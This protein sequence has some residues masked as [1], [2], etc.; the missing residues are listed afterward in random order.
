VEEMASFREQTCM[1]YGQRTNLE[2][3][4]C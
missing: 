2:Y 1:S 4:C 3:R